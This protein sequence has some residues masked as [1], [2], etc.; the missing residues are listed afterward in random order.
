[1]ATMS[2]TGSVLVLLFGTLQVA[3]RDFLGSSSAAQDVTSQSAKYDIATDLNA[4]LINDGS[5][6]LSRGESDP[7][8]SSMLDTSGTSG[9]DTDLD[10]A[11]STRKLS[12]AK[13]NGGGSTI[14]RAGNSRQ[15]HEGD[16]Q[17]DS[18]IDVD[19]LQ[20]DVEQ[21]QDELAHGVDENFSRDLGEPE[22]DTSP[23]NVYDT[24]LLQGKVDD[25]QDE[26]L[27][28][29]MLLKALSPTD[30]TL[31]IRIQDVANLQ[32]VVKEIQ[33]ELTH[34]HHASTSEQASTNIDPEV[35]MVLLQ[36]LKKHTSIFRHDSEK[37]SMQS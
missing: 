6:K 12:K 34:R 19:R 10:D 29:L 36:K 20:N 22:T 7:P 9:S 3:G 1:M 27:A 30:Q 18:S 13:L 4:V 28:Q 33:G 31:A 21:L 23:G 37:L 11:H 24:T 14:G 17:D 35:I 16:V 15:E 26:L 8:A 25:I 5:M 32:R 2:L